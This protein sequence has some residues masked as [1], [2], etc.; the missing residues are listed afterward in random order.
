MVARVL[1]LTQPTVF[2]HKAVPA[3]SGVLGTRKSRARS[4]LPESTVCWRGYDVHPPLFGGT[5]WFRRIPLHNSPG[6]YLAS[7]VSNSAMPHRLV[8]LQ[9]EPERT[10]EPLVSAAD[11]SLHCRPTDR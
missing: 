7:P 10:R 11:C 9:R 1:Q 8:A 5:I 3:S 4:F 6:L 2:I